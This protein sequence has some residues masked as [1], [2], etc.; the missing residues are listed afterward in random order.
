M[1][2]TNYGRQFEVR[3]EI[4]PTN[5]AYTGMGLQAH[6]DNP[7]RDP[8]PTIQVLYCLGVRPRAVTVRLSTALPRR[9]VY[10][11][12]TAVVRRAADTARFEYAGRSGTR[13][14]ARKAM[15]ELAPDGELIGVS[16]TTGRP[17]R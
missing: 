13:L 11:K 3:T 5:L 16:S 1:S 8:V 10:A 2:E 6:T 4:N 9:G 7:Y 15:I 12:K 14:V 17:Q